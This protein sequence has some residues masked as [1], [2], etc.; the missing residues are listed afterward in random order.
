MIQAKKNVDTSYSSERTCGWLQM[1]WLS[2]SFRYNQL[3]LDTSKKS[4]II[5]EEFKEYTSK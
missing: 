4:L 2:L 1:N 3:K 5:L